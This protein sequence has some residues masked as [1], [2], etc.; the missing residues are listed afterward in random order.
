MSAI[1]ELLTGA[2]LEPHD[3]AVTLLTSSV[4]GLCDNN[5]CSPCSKTSL[6]YKIH[7]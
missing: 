7:I 1:F 5:Q 4:C 2:S 6:I 3:S